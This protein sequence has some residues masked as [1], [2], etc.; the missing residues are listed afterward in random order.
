MDV[1]LERRREV[2]C[3]RPRLVASPFRSLSSAAIRLHRALWPLLF[4][5]ILALGACN[6][7]TQS[8]YPSTPIDT[9]SASGRIASD[10]KITVYQG[11]NILGGEETTFFDLLGQGKPVVLNFW[12]GACPPCRAEMP[13]LQE[14]FTEYQD[15]VLLFGLDIGP[16]VGLGSRDSGRALL[17]ELGISYPAGT[18]FDAAVVR[19]Y[20]IL[21]MPTTVFLQPTGEVFTTWTGLLNRDK[22]TELI[23]GLLL[24]SGSL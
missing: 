14:A 24:A 17:E 13:D 11:Q 18:T 23:E 21:G 8:S 3:L 22:A 19:D 10:F 9:S 16:F 4:L 7:G 5:I 6:G 2:P 12:A 20:Q 1:R 15:R